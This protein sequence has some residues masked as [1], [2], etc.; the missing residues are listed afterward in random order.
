MAKK[1]T[2]KSPKT[3]KTARSSKSKSS[4]PSRKTTKVSGGLSQKSTS[5]SYVRRDSS[6]GQF[7]SA[8]T[9]R[10]IKSTPA[11]SR[12]GKER[13]RTAVRNYVRRAA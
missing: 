13:I 5:K 10:I 9:G 4:K 7:K 2:S 8:K 12:L 3:A 6:T 11:T 1:I